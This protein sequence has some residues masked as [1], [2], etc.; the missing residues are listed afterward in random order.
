M[1]LGDIIYDILWRAMIYKGSGGDCRFLLHLREDSVT[2][3]KKSLDGLPHSHL[4]L[5]DF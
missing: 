2:P 5:A 3:V 4:T 1:T